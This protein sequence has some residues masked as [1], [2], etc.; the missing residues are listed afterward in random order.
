MAAQKVDQQNDSHFT[1][2]QRWVA[3]TV[4]DLEED[5]DLWSLQFI[6]AYLVTGSL[7]CNKYMI[8]KR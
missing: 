8:N 4:A 1:A 2:K 3:Q 6:S 7:P 5:L